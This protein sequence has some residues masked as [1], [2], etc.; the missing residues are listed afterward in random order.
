MVTVRTFTEAELA[1]FD[2]PPGPAEDPY[3]FFGLPR[4]SEAF[5]ARWAENRLI[6]DAVSTL[7]VDL[8]GAVIG[9]VQWHVVSY[10]PPPM[11][12]AFNI[13]IGSCQHTRP[14]PRHECAGSAGGVSA[15]HV[16]GQS[17]R[18]QYRRHKRRRTEVTGEGGIHPRGRPPRR[19]M[20]GRR[21][22]GHGSLFPPPRRCS[23]CDPAAQS[24]EL[25]RAATSFDQS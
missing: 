17:D 16:P 20:A 25:T 1:Y 23:Y 15:R 22:E 3:S 10:G 14:G 18:G 12:N 19:S 24:A 9:D 13:G 11:S 7:A 5:R 6:G 21:V 8:D 4:G 2:S